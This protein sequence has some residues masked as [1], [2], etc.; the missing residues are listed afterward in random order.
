MA[1]KPKKKLK[2]KESPPKRRSWI[3]R[4]PAGVMT[5]LVLALVAYI[6]LRMIVTTDGFRFYLGEHLTERWDCPVTIASSRMNRWLDLTLGGVEGGAKEEVQSAGHFFFHKVRLDMDYT[7]CLLGSRRSW[8]RSIRVD[9][10]EVEFGLD[11]DGVGQ[12]EFLYTDWKEFLTFSGIRASAAKGGA[13]VQ[14]PARYPEERWAAL[15]ALH[16]T[17]LSVTD[18][19]SDRADV[20]LLDRAELVVAPLTVPGREVH[21]VRLTSVAGGYQRAAFRDLRLEWVSSGGVPAIMENRVDW[22]STLQRPARDPAPSTPEGRETVRY[23][24]EQNPVASPK[25]PTRTEVEET[26]K[27]ALQ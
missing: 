3:S 25:A 22:E 14:H 4:V 15:P 5:L 2:K 18:Q 7:A 8:I 12:P 20:L 17:G 21:Y 16:V 13:L 10:G 23:Y 26:L 1:Q 19:A 6:G 9:E 24:L 27:Q 11:P